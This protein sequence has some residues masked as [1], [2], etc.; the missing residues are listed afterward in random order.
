MHFDEMYLNLSFEKENYDRLKDRY[1][2]KL[3]EIE[4]GFIDSEIIMNW[5]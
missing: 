5:R 4:L 2:A 1:I 3:D